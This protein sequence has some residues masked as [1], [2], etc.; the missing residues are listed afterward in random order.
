VRTKG[1]DGGKGGIGEGERNGAGR[2]RGDREEMKAEEGDREG[3]NREERE[4]RKERG[5]RGGD[6]NF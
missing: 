5:G 2:K 3:R 4:R 1:Y 6:L